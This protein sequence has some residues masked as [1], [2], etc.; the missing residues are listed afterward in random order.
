MANLN[1]TEA[2]VTVTLTRELA[3]GR[4]LVGVRAVSLDAD[5]APLRQ[6]NATDLFDQLTPT[7]QAQAVAITDV[8]IAYVKGQLGIA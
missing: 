5:G 1:E 8:A 6:F 4:T 2:R 7:R 3:T